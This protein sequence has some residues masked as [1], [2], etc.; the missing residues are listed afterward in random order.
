MQTRLRKMF[1]AVVINKNAIKSPV[2]FYAQLFETVVN[3]NGS[4]DHGVM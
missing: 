1:N 4:V 3:G 2:T